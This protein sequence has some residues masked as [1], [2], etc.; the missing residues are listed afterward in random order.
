MMQKRFDEAEAAYQRAL[1]IDPE[2][3]LTQINIEKLVY[4]RENPDFEPEFRVSTPFA[5]MKTSLT[6][7]EED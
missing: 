5:D 2:Y 3:E 6:I 7:I 4:M 1:E